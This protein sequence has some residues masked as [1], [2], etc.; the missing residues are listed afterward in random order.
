[1]NDTAMEQDLAGLAACP[2]LP[3]QSPGYL[4]L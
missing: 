1:M 4:S 3:Y 2:C